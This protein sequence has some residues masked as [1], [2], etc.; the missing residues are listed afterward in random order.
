MKQATPDPLR[1]NSSRNCSNRILAASLFG[2]FFF[3]LFPYWID[4]SR[5]S[6][7]GRSIFLLGR[8][9][10][11]DGYLH[12]SLNALLF[13]PFGLALWLSFSGRKKSLLRSIALALLAGAAL[14]YSIEMLQLW[15]PSR[16]SAWDD[17]LANA[18]GALIGMLLGLGAGDFIFRKLSELQ[19]YVEQVL[20]LRNIFIS[21]AIYFG[22]WLAVS[23]PLQQKT[24]LNNWDPNSDMFLA[25]DAREDTRWPGAV[26]LVQ[27]WDRAL[28]AHQAAAISENADVSQEIPRPLSS[29]DLSQ[30]LPIR[31]KT[32]TLPNLVLN[33]VSTIQ[34][35]AHRARNDEAPPVLMSDGPV[36]LLA[37][38]VRRTNQFSI[39][40]HC[41]PAG[42]NASDGAIFAIAD[43]S[44]KFDFNLRQEYSS[45]VI[46]LKTGLDSRKT[47]LDLHVPNVFS[48]IAVRSILFS[49]DGAQ[50]SVYVDGREVPKSYYLSPGAALVGELVRIKT[51]ELVAYTVLYQSLVFLPVGFLLG[52]A[53]RNTSDHSAFDKFGIGIAI[54]IPASVLETTLVVVSGR[55]FSMLQL[56]TSIGLIVAGMLWINLDSQKPVRSLV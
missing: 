5:K 43:S 10:G 45:A 44:G 2:I 23:I 29:Y 31:D 39:L 55:H 28:T 33:A 1:A 37:A 53:A 18:F 11:F 32:A 14:S 3:T 16:D 30:T 19:S 21:V 49:Y 48:A 6:S 27:F 20:S 9:L 7:S 50:G 15:I 54:I 4:F 34:V 25:Y 13:V 52:L 8:S 24:H 56:S 40:V 17:V 12:T 42:V 38:A 36:P 26:S 22:M 35:A 41:V 46:S 51:D 47:M